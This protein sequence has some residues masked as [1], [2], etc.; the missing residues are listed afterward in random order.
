MAVDPN[1]EAAMARVDAEGNA[2]GATVQPIADRLATLAD[3]LSRSMTAEEQAAAATRL[4]A[5]S[6]ALDTVAAALTALGQ[7][8]TNPVPTP[9]A[10]RSR[11]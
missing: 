10:T 5:D 6:D 4:Q 7:S 11:Q 2:I 9:F 1:L 8:P 3:Q